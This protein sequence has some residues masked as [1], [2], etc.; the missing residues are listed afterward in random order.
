MDGTA[1]PPSSYSTILSLTKA[2]NLAL[3]GYIYAND[4]ST[5]L[6]SATSSGTTGTLNVLSGQDTYAGVYDASIY[7]GGR[8]QDLVDNDEVIG[9]RLLVSNTGAANSI[10]N[11]QVATG[12]V[13]G[14]N[15][16]PS[17]YETKVSVT[18]AGAT[19]NDILTLTVRSTT[20]ASQPTGSIICSGSGA[21]NH[22]YYYNGSAWRQLDN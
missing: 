21:N 20:P 11:I 19:I 14:G 2:G 8:R 22:L 9:Y 4:A 13:A 16:L 1:T 12:S 7:I 17:K 6:Q 10:F 5:I 3:N 18:N 15:T